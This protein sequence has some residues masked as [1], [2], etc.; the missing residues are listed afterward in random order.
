M[1]NNY[2]LCKLRDEFIRV[3]QSKKHQFILGHFFPILEYEAHEGCNLHIP[4]LQPFCCAVLCHLVMSDSF[5]CHGLQPA[6]LFCPWGFFR[7][8]Y[9]SCHALLQ[10]ILP[11]QGLNPGLPH[12]RR[13]HYHL[14]HLIPSDTALQE[15][16][17][18]AAF[19]FYPHFTERKQK[20]GQVE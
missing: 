2:C 11:T 7:Q 6:R 15:L 12:C 19:Y 17:Q 16:S 3:T 9:W 8:E 5:W 13:I 10:G 4:W 1:W 20:V 18:W 14:S